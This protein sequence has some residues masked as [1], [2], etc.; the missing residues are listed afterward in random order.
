VRNAHFHCF[1]GISGDMTVGALIDAGLDFNEFKKN[2]EMLNISGYEIYADDVLK[3]GIKGTCF[4]VRVTEDQGCRNLTDIAGI[5]KKSALPDRVKKDSIRIFELLAAAEAKVHNSSVD[6]IH[7]HEVGAIDSIIDICGTAIAM[8]MHGIDSVTNSPVNTGKGFVKSEH[9]ILPVP[10]PATAELLKRSE[11]YSGDADGELT[12]PTG[13]A[14]IAYYS[15]GTVPLP[16]MRNYTTGYGAG[17]MDLST[18]NLLRVFIYDNDSTGYLTDIVS[19]IETTIDDMNPEIFSH[20]FEK[21][22]ETGVLDAV[23]LPAFTKKNRP[24]SVLKV[25]VSPRMADEAAEIIFR[26]TT[27]SGLR[28]REVHRRILEREN[29]HV[30]TEYGIINV[31]IHYL[32]GKIVTVS[33]EYEDC[34]KAAL[35]HNVSVKKIYIEAQKIIKIDE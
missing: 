10:A 23:I 29:K 19:E 9:G 12:T 14:I 31:K 18:P 13:A 7:F 25:L 6:K 35:K 34:R 32:H 2:L 5:I 8:W 11:I 17:T 26:E 16:E 28:I 22:Y 33:P 21:L 15:S 30:E 24:A 1:S 20:L 27:T 3:N 4:R